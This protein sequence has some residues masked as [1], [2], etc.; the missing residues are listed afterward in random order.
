MDN[1]DKITELA[2]DI[3][4]LKENTRIMRAIQNIKMP[5]EVREALFE[6]C[7]DK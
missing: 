3:G 6:I 5:L 7:N 1:Y 4:V 2:T